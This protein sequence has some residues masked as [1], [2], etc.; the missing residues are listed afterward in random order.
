MRAQNR[1]RS[2]IVDFGSKDDCRIVP[3][4]DDLKA[5]LMIDVYVD[6]QWL[7]PLI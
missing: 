6:R 7:R 3:T 1:V 2:S 4:H 5:H